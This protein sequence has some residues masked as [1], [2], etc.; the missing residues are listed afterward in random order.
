MLVLPEGIEYIG[1]EAFVIRDNLEG[2]AYDMIKV[3]ESLIYIGYEA[4]GI[5]PVGGPDIVLC[6]PA[7]AYAEEYCRNHR[8]HTYVPEGYR[9][10]DIDHNGVINVADIMTLKSDIMRDTFQDA[11]ISDLDNDGKIT[12]SD[13]ISLKDKIMNPKTNTSEWRMEINDLFNA[14]ST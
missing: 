1:S 2:Y 10:G 3:P 8:K 14:I 9:T 7:G 4:L 13:M 6:G 5:M 11:E 12:V